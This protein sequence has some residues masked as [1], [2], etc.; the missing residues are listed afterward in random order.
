VEYI[1]FI[2]SI[3][4]KEKISNKRQAGGSDMFLQIIG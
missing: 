3:E 4:D 1:A 2:F